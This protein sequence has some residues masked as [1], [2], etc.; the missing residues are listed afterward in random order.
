MTVDSEYPQDEK[1]VLLD[2]E[3]RAPAQGALTDFPTPPRFEHLEDRMIYTAGLQGA[4]SFNIGPNTLV[5]AAWELL[6]QVVQLKGN[7]GRE[8]L[9][10][11]NDRLSSGITAF[12]T[13]ALYQ[14]A[15]NSEVMSARYVLCSVI[16]EAVVTTAWGNRS[17]WS[18]TSL[19]SRFHN[20]TFGG[21]KFFQLLERLS[22]DPV[23]HLAMLELMYLCLSLGFEGKYRVLERGASQL[24]TVRDG[25]FRQI[26]HVRGDRP[27][28]TAPTATVPAAG[29][30]LRII[31]VTRVVIFTVVCLL[32]MYSGFAWVLGNERMTVLQPFQPLAPDQTRSS[33]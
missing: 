26:R 21:E 13:R 5:A 14:G 15:E 22:R 12:E 24:E 10:S 3:G 2:R 27:S 16:D 25:L 6:A 11:L 31:S 32:A 4:Q 17:D 29:A 19:L 7:A 8:S 33:L 20:E 9:Q 23:K 30:R 18:K 28:M 1:T